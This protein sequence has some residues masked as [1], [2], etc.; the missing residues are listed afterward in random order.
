MRLFVYFIQKAFE[1][2]SSMNDVTYSF[3][4]VFYSRL[5][6]GTYYYLPLI[7][8]DEYNILQLNIQHSMEIFT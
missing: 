1:F 5:L 6:N 7:K 2:E 3:T 4:A 8:D